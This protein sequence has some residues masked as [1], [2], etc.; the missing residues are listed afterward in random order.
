MA[1]TEPPMVRFVEQT[2]R[3]A[4]GEG[5]PRIAGRMMALL[6][7]S[8]RQMGIDEIA[9]ELRVSRASVSTNGQL[10]RQLN[11]AEHVTLPGDRRDYLQI[12]G[13]PCSALLNLGLRR[14]RTMRDAVRELKR[15]LQ[16]GGPIVRARLN[17]TERC[18][19]AAVSRVESLLGSWRRGRSR[20]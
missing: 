14:L 5:L 17:Q 8:G 9:T 2:G 10:L 20:E 4:E 7:V 11:I 15:A 3:L 16:G 18:Y 19:D 6:M 13:D 1:R 12:S